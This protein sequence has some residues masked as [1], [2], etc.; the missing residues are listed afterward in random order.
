MSKTKTLAEP[1]TKAVFSPELTQQP[2]PPER[3][4]EPVLHGWFQPL[5]ATSPPPAE[6]LPAA[7]AAR[8]LAVPHMGGATQR[9]RVLRT[10]QNVVGNNRV[11]GMLQSTVQTKLTVNAPGDIY[12]QEADRVAETVMRMPETPIQRQV[13]PEEEETLQTKPLTAQI[14]SLVQRQVEP[15]EEEGLVQAQPAPGETPEVTPDMEDHISASR[16]SGEPLAGAVRAFA[17][18]RFGADFSGVRVHTDARSSQVARGLNAQAFTTG[19]DIYFGAGQY[20]PGTKQGDRLLAHELTHVVQQK[21]NRTV[22]NN[23]SPRI[24]ISQPNNVQEQKADKVEISMI[25]TNRRGQA[26]EIHNGVIQRQPGGQRTVRV[27][28]DPTNPTA[29][30]FLGSGKIRQSFPEEFEAALGA[31]PAAGMRT[32]QEIT[33]AGTPTTGEQRDIFEQRLRRLVRMTALGLMASHRATIEGKRD[34]FLGGLNQPQESGRRALG[35]KEQEP[36]PKRAETLQAIRSAAQKIT[37][38]NRLKDELEGYRNTFASL[39][40]GVLVQMRTESRVEAWLGRMRSNTIQYTSP[41]IIDYFNERIKTLGQVRNLDLMGAAL[42]LMAR[43]LKEW[44]QRQLDGVNV[45]LYYLH[46]AFPFFTEL[47]PERVT[48]SEDT[49]DNRLEQDVRKAFNDLIEKIDNAIIEIGSEDIHPFDLPEAVRVSKGSLPPELQ[50]SMEQVLQHR[51]TIKFWTTMGLTLLQALLVFVPVVGPFLAAGLG[52]VSLGSDVED[53]LDRYCLSQASNQPGEGIL[54]VD[55]PGKL[56]WTMMAIQAALTIADL[57]AGWKAMGEWRPSVHPEAEPPATHPEGEAHSGEAGVT[58]ERGRTEASAQKPHA[59]G[60]HPGGPVHSRSEVGYPEGLVEFG[61]DGHEARRSFRASLTEDVSREAGIWMDPQTREYVVVQG[62]RDFVETEWM[63]HR[64]MLRGGRRPNWQLIEHYHPDA[65][66]IDRLPSHDDFKSMMHW[67]TTGAESPHEI[68][69]VIRYTDPQ[70]HIEFTSRFGY[71]PEHSQPYWVE[72]RAP[73]SRWITRRFSEPPWNP[74]S[75]Y[76]RF[77]EQFGSSP[78]HSTLTGIPGLRAPISSK[79]K[80]AAAGVSGEG[81]A[82]TGKPK[83][84]PAPETPVPHTG[85]TLSSKYSN[86]TIRQLRKLAVTDAEAAEALRLRYRNMPDRQLAD[87]AGRGDAMA[88]SVRSQRFPANKELLKILGS[89]YRPPHEATAVARDSKGK[90]MW[91]RKLSSGNMTPAEKA[92]GY[93]QSALATHTEARAVTQAPLV[94]GGTLAISGQYDPCSSCQRAMAA[95]ATKSGATIIYW[96]P[97]GRMVFKP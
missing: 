55:E 37:F 65:R 15:E 34:E 18:P 29:W 49:S 94:R 80:A 5:V 45:S 86:L 7:H 81:K 91:S 89:D 31:A 1:Q 33:A 60:T 38:L 12:E 36:R 52:A 53:M 61:L 72:Y 27:P 62:G 41:E 2:A 24:P 48:K 43:H 85:S 87:L 23:L 76:S 92:L 77:L 20:Q 46:Q 4:S 66:L 35:G 21:G 47:D 64:E 67:Q 74:G 75:D 93:P 97:G 30:S 3:Q 78:A 73:D 26:V 95:A 42:S 50:R 9:V 25:S 68:T 59:S 32:Q 56:E 63:N 22:R 84:K 14:T 69:S 44:R 10:L 88:E 51:Q 90:I 70:T 16:G 40:S 96:W 19:Q 54:G 8:M 17:E 82:L 71:S 28:L 39:E 6:T 79:A 11:G 57:R 83:T 58:G 13:E